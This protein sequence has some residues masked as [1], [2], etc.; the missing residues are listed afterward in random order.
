MTSDTLPFVCL[1]D[2]RDI[3]VTIASNNLIS[4]NT[5][6]EVTLCFVCIASCRLLLSAGRLVSLT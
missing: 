4:Y 1:V 2:F 6:L 3:P 5:H